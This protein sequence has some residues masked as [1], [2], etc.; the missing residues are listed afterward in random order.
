MET[1]PGD[2]RAEEHMRRAMRNRFVIGIVAGAVALAV[3]IGGISGGVAYAANGSGQAGTTLAVEGQR[4][5]RRGAVVLVAGLVKVTAEVTGL[6][7]RQVAAEVRAGK[8]LEQIAQANGKTAQDV[9]TAARTKLNQRLD[10]AVANNRITQ[11]RA[12]ELL[13]QFDQNAP[14]VMSST[15]LAQQLRQGRR[16]QNAGAALVRTTADVTG[17][18]PEQVRAELEA[19]KSL[20]QIAQA[21]GKTAD[22]VLAALRSQGQTRLD[23]LLDKAREKISAPNLGR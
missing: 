17:L 7:P 13:A 3:G 14:Q 6:T 23:E 11:T 20:E 18:T 10:Q 1:T 4:E 8:S 9:I 19:G 5:G 12:D 2:M 21:N 22:D 15:T 16:G